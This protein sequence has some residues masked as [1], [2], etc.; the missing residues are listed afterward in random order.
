MPPETHEIAHVSD[1][2]LMTAACRAIETDRPDGLIRDPFAAQLAGARGMAI[3]R[4]L[5]RLDVMCFGI[6]I[7]SRFLDHLVTDTVAAHGI[8]HRAQPGRG[9]GFASVAVGAARRLTWVEVDFPEMLDYKDGVLASAA[10]KCRRERLAAD[11][12]DASGR[13]S[14]F[15]AA[16]GPTLLITEGLLMY[17]PAPT[18]DALASTT[19][20]NYWMLDVASERDEAAHANEF[21]SVHR[22]RARRGSHRRR[23]DSGRSASSQLDRLRSLKY[24]TDV[25]TYA[26]DRIASMFR[27]V[28]PGPDS[29]SQCRQAT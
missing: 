28:P 14:V 8:A 11:V 19:T 1:T 9:V 6:G 10:P 21:V 13:Q 25:M 4:A 27:N 20:V 2:A 26:A 12:N 5:D 23:G 29:K 22:E 24:A 17:L 3:A 7:R 18:V 16:A 15:A